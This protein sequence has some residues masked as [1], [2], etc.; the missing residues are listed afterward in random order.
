MERQ[1]QQIYSKVL[2]LI[3]VSPLFFIQKTTAQ[4]SVAREWNEVLL[5]GIRG[6]FARPTI[7]ARN[8][9]HVS[10]AMY[11]AWAVYDEVAEP[12]FLGKTANGFTCPFDSI[13]EP[14]DIEAARK[15][16]ISYAAYRIIYQRFLYSPG[17]LA[18]IPMAT[19]L[20][21]DLG[22]DEDVSSTDYST[23]SPAALGNYIAMKVLEYGLED[24]SS[25]GDNFNN[26][27]YEPFNI[28]LDM[29]S[30]GNPTIVDP[31]RWQPLK[32]NVFVD[33]SGNP[34]PGG[35]PPFLSPEWGNVGPFALSD[36][37]KTTYLRDGNAYQVYHDPSTPPT[38][39]TNG[40]LPDEYKWGFSMVSI[41]GSHLDPSDN[42]MIDISPASIGNNPTLPANYEDY[43]NFY[44]YID[45]G[46]ASQG[47]TENPKTGQPYAPQIVPRADYARV[48]AE[49]WADGP[50]SET[51][52]GHWFSILNYVSDHPELVK[53][54]K[55]E[56]ALMGNLEWD[57]KSYFTLA[58]AMHDAAITAWGVKGWYDYLRPVSAIRFMA[59]QGQSTNPNLPNY[60]PE[61][62]I[63]LVEG[64][65]E[66]VQAGDSLAGPNGENINKIKVYTWRGPGYIVSPDS[67]IAGVGWILAENWW[68]YQRPSFVTP[69]F[70]G[71]VSGHSTFSRAAAEV[72]TML[73]GDPF[74]PGGMG[75][76]EAPKGEFLVFE[77]GPSVDL[78]LQWATYQD[79]SDQTSLSRIWGGIH[80]PAD[81]IPGR[82]IGR[83]IGID[84]FNF[85][86]KYF[87]GKANAPTFEAEVTV[88][89]NPIVNESRI[90]VAINAP[91]TELNVQL[92]N[93]Q[94]QV[95]LSEVRMISEDTP[96]FEMNLKGF[97][98]GVYFLNLSSGEL[99]A[100]EK[101]MLLSE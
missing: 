77:D 68:P 73:T 86:E 69:P 44:D 94:G 18:T 14:A 5:T 82:L 8:L 58:G 75:E 50:E 71:F 42:V 43:R 49:F 41:W 90:T 7:H 63:P 79:A 57:I 25:E 9:M 54:Y 19:N 98:T 62:G 2:L 6:D 84:A 53:K 16:A 89:P 60:N 61:F 21:N 87:E 36:N 64:Y 34:I 66:Q 22:Y 48:L 92:I 39:G 78:T 33:Q 40:Y 28:A 3:L 15:E 45:G 10:I 52:P 95:V 91:V 76:F 27:Y 83:E 35:V 38:I 72:L 29:D 97:G 12:Y 65:I 96:Y 81:D 59:D 47:H 30:S 26:Q 70:S 17:A 37:D 11:D 74:F 55:G 51:P 31:N 100:T 93:A 1:L 20:L 88:F 13:L 32:L 101:L 23:G 85:A 24:G 67:T 99:R 4:H 46:D 80:P 56:G